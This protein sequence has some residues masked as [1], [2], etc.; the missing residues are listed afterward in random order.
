MKMIAA[1]RLRKAEERAM[2]ARP[3]A[4]RLQSFLDGFTISPE[5]V[6]H[7][8]AETRGT[9]RK[10]G[11]LLITSDR[12]LCGS[13]N[14]N[15]MREADNWLNANERD[16]CL[17]YIIGKKGVNYYK[18]RGGNIKYSMLDIDQT[19]NHKQIKE[20]TDT[21]AAD[22]I[23]GEVDEVNVL[24]SKY[25]SPAVCKQ[26]NIPLL[27][28]R[29]AESATEQKGPAA[30]FIYQPSSE[31]LLEILFPKYLYTR[32]ITS[33]AESFASEQGQRMVA[34]TNA[35]D[36][37]EEMVRLL[38]LKYNNARQTAITKELLEIVGGAEALEK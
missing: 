21:L 23:A 3:Y 30:D 35:T 31:A 28:I 17:L 16:N 25:V 32:I 22:F 20:I 29:S 12:G 13:Y 24:Y 33:L 5:N 18:R 9:I 2:M 8:L 4:D 14:G 1:A 26:T 10:R 11:L 7:P 15:I 38:T 19:I 27:P 36:N 34:M 6:P 37:A